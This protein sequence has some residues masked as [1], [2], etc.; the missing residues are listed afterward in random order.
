MTHTVGVDIGGTFT[1]CIVVGDDGRL[2]IGKAPSTPPD[3]ETGFIDALA[4]GA[5]NAGMSLDELVAEADGIFHGCTVGTNALVENRTAIVG[6]LT[7]RG[8]RDAIAIMRGG[9]RLWNQPPDYVAHLADHHKDAPLIPKNLIEEI[10]ERIT[11]DGEIVVP[12]NEQSAVDAIRRLIKKGCEAIAI[13]CIWSVANPVHEQRLL[14]LVREHAPGVFV[15]VASD[16]VNR[17][18]EYERTTAAVINALI[19]SVVQDYLERVER[20]LQELGFRR[21]LQIMTCTGGVVAATEARRRPILTM[22][23]GPVGGLIGAGALAS[24]SGVLADAIPDGGSNGHRRGVADIITADMGGTTLDVGV[25]RHGEPIRRPTS[26]HGQYEYFVPTLDVQSIGAGGGSIVRYDELLSTLRVGP[27][28]AGA[29]PGPACYGRGGELATVTDA[30]LVAGFIDPHK[31]LGGEMVLQEDLAR[32]ALAAAGTPLGFDDEQTAAATLRIVESQMADAIRLASVQQGYDP[33]TFS[34]FAFGGAGPLHGAALARELGIARVVIPLSDLAS[35][36]SAFGIASADVLVV[37]D[38]AVGLT[39][40]F[41]PAELSGIWREVE[42]RAL[43][44]MTAQSVP[45]DGVVLERAVEMRYRG[46]VNEVEV[47][48][49]DG[50]YDTARVEELVAS[51]EAEYGRLFGEGTGYAA[52][53]MAITRLIVRARAMA[54]DFAIE[55]APPGQGAS[56]EP[57]GSRDVL[58]AHGRAPVPVYDGRSLVPG[59]QV[60]GPGIIEFPDTSVVVPDAATVGMDAFGSVVV[61]LH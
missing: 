12:L 5:Q 8:H 34:L 25:L 44:R 49:P 50:V 57:I 19:G 9:Q 61:E 1:D 32:R 6:L 2:T 33:R 60:L 42:E 46:Q 15:S 27:K 17:T 30:D 21:P 28:S 51:F 38:Y 11:F 36:W 59:H 55:L 7:T 26:W 20:R 16:V 43:S 52:A 14:D 54:S 31:F 24:A 37:E 3:F 47:P 40:P 45:A 23:S 48:A 29:R 39:S 35:G 4:A 13:S 53:G 58:R 56:M 22:H 18:G 10:D 41:S